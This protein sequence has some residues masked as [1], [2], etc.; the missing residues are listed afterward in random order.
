MCKCF[1]RVNEK[2]A[3][4]N[5][6]LEFNFLADPPR[7]MVSVCKAKSRGKKPP[8]MEAT[9]CPFC[10]GRYRDKRISVTKIADAA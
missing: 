9:Y 7:A 8:L 1:E 5:G 2:L 10:G 3:D 6:M 4:Y